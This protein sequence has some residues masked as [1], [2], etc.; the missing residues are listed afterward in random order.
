MV[1]HSPQ[2]PGLLRLRLWLGPMWSAKTNALI[3]AVDASRDDFRRIVVVKHTVDTRHPTHVVARSGLT[4]PADVRTA[5]LASV[6]LYT[7]TLYA[8]DEAQFF[9]PGQL[10][11][12]WRAVLQLDGSSLAVAGLDYDYARREFGGVLALARLAI[13]GAQQ[14]PG[15]PAATAPASAAPV[16]PMEIHRLAARCAH[17]DAKTGAPCNK[18]ALFSQRLQAG[19]NAQVRVGGEDAYRPACEGHHTPHPVPAE[20]GWAAAGRTAGGGKGKL[21]ARSVP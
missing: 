4:L 2:R 17:V 19:G 18:P 11:A 1:I 7:R 10:T 13:G 12:F 6:R 5:D 16:V 20:E 8:V 3:Q 9:E 15:A 21:P 14:E